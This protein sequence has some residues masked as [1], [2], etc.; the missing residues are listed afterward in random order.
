MWEREK[1]EVARGDDLLGE[2]ARIRLKVRHYEIDEYGHVN[3]AHYVHY[4]EVGRIEALEGV[5][6]P[7]AAMREQGYLIVAAELSIRFHAPARSGE[8][9]DVVT[10]IREVRG[11]RSM[12]VQ[13]IREAASQR[14]LATAEV[15]GA[16]MTEGGRPVRIPATF[17]ERLSALHVPSESDAS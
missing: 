5:G 1:P 9:L 7:L 2:P 4:F 14:L 15:T 3:H 6:L 12:W 11:A 17:R 13:E 8:T 16:F 10:R